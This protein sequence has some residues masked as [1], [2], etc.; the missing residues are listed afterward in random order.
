VLALRPGSSRVT[1]T[2]PSSPFSQRTAFWSV[3]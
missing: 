2:I 1:T 3:T